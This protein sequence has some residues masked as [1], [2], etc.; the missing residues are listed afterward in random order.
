MMIK[1]NM[2]IDG[3]VTG[4]KAKVDLKQPSNFEDAVRLAKEKEWKIRRQRELGILVDDAYMQRYVC[5]DP[6]AW[7]TG[8]Y[9]TPPIF[10]KQK[11]GLCGSGLKRCL[12]AQRW[13]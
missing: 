13:M 8:M 12:K 10:E 9:Y 2:F 6:I 5:E 7:T 1:K 11:S 3:L 4:L